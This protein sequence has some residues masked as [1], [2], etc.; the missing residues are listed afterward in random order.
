MRLNL[1]QRESERYDTTTIGEFDAARVERLHEASAVTAAITSL[2][3]ARTSPHG[4]RM[5]CNAYVSSAVV[6][7]YLADRHEVRANSDPA[8]ADHY[9]ERAARHREPR[10]RTVSAP[11]VC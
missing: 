8:R 1:P 5:V 7:E 9:R 11:S 4:W 2:D 6:H 3:Q 10:S